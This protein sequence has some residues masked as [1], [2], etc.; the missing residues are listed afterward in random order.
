L[1]TGDMLSETYPAI[2]SLITRGSVPWDV[3]ADNV[4][5]AIGAGGNV[6][7]DQQL[8]N[9]PFQN[10]AYSS[11]SNADTPATSNNSDGT[12]SQTGP[13]PQVQQ[14]SNNMGG[15]AMPPAGVNK[16]AQEFGALC[17]QGMEWLITDLVNGGDST[18]PNT[19]GSDAVNPSQPLTNS[20]VNIAGNNGSPSGLTGDEMNWESWDDLVRQYAGGYPAVNSSTGLS[21]WY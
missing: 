13:S 2:E 1:G 19:A 7:I 14:P 18:L 16:A 3:H 8:A 4:A 20:P 5:K 17:D 6:F 21:P 12:P 10:Q 9:Q 11:P 15:Q